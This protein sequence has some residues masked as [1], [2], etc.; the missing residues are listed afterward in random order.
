MTRRTFALF[1]AWLATAAS[2]PATAQV[3][4]PYPYT[5]DLYYDGNQYAD[6]YFGWAL[7]GGW[8]AQ[9]SGWEM[10]I[11]LGEGY[12]DA[13]TSW[14]N[15]PQPYD[16]C[17]TAGTLDPS[18]RRNFG[19]GSFDKNQIVGDVNGGGAYRGQWW[20]C[21]GSSAS[22]YPDVAWQEV[23][24][25]IC[26]DRYNIWCYEGVQGSRLLSAYWRYTQTAYDEWDY[27]AQVYP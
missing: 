18:G 22:T 26:S 4:K 27:Y 23:T 1:A 14:T 7:P 20:F 19:I 17:P 12:F 25:Q 16:D 21:G 13:C 11:S 5:G 9:T 24:T 15:L 6:S 8:R 2:T 3:P 10:D